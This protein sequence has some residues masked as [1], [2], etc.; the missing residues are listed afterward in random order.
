MDP[1]TLAALKTLGAA[2]GGGFLTFCVMAGF[3]WKYIRTAISTAREMAAKAQE[4]VDKAAETPIEQ[5]R[6]IVQR[7]DRQIQAQGKRMTELEHAHSNCE[8]EQRMLKLQ[9]STQQ[10]Q[11]DWSDKVIT[12]MMTNVTKLVEALRLKGISDTD[13]GLIPLPEKPPSWTKVDPAE[14]TP[15]PPQ[16]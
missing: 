12:S 8:S 16:H 11:M 6:L 4:V 3:T 5:W 2:A 9:N 15:Y 10:R 13:I 7:Q 14:K 1:E